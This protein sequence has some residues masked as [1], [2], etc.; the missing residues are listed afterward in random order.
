MGPATFL[1]PVVGAA[2][3][4]MKGN[5]SKNIFYSSSGRWV[6]QVQ[7]HRIYHGDATHV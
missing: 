2:K 5:R 3:R 1:T 6:K 4:R 7:Q